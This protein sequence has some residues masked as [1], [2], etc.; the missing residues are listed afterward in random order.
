[1]RKVWRVWR[2]WSVST[3]VIEHAF[4]DRVLGLSSF[5]LSNLVTVWL[6]CI[7]YFRISNVKV[8]KNNRSLYFNA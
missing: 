7:V 8:T 4:H 1:V 2:V 5:T 6:S 3:W